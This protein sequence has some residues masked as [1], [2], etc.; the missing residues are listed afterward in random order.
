MEIYHKFRD[1]ARIETQSQLIAKMFKAK[2]HRS[3]ATLIL[4][5]AALYFPQSVEIL[6]FMSF[7]YDKQKQFYV[8]GDIYTRLAY[9]DHT[10]SHGVVEYLKKSGRKI[11]AQILNMSVSHQKKQLIQKLSIYIDNEDYGL[12]HS[13]EVPLHQVGAFDNDDV[14]YAFA[15]VQLTQGKYDASA[16]QLKSIKKSSLINRSLKLLDIVKGCKKSRWECYGHF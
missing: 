13:L 9:I 3:K 16:R 8:A 6:S 10:L 2:G 5:E 15:Y 7:L 4:E 11:Q 1:P 12:A 14:K